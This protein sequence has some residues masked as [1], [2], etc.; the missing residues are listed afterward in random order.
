MGGTMTE[1]ILQRRL[2][3]LI[4]LRGTSALAVSIA[5]GLSRGA[6]RDILAGKS[7]QPRRD[8]LQRIANVLRVDI[9]YLLGQSD[10]PPAHDQ[11]NPVLPLRK[12][13]RGSGSTAASRLVPVIGIAEAGVFRAMPLNAREPIR[14]LM[15]VPHHW[16][17]EGARAPNFALEVPKARV[18]GIDYDAGRGY[19]VCS[20]LSEAG[21]VIHTGQTYAVVRKRADMVETVMRKA[22]V[23]ADHIDLTAIDNPHDIVRTG[24]DL[25]DDDTKSVYVVGVSC[26]LHFE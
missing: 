8:T 7:D 6:V 21:A 25:D 4:V 17:P 14:V 9:A 15:V 19:M 22:V 20:P 18:I 3:E 2:R 11:P 26:G 16:V 23:Y 10:N 24:R 12:S 5:A 13:R 1:T